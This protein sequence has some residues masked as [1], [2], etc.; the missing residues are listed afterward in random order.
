MKA[1]DIGGIDIK[2]IGKTYVCEK[3][4][5]YAIMISDIKPKY[6]PYGCDLNEGNKQ[7]KSR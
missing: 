7:R 1:K 3:C 2:L 5:R 6:C 4:L